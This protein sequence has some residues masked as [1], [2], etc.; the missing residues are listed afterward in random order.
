M[1]LPPPHAPPLPKAIEQIRRKY[2]KGKNFWGPDPLTCRENVAI[3]D[4]LD[5]I[6]DLQRRIREL[7]TM[8]S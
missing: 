1:N 7:E 4:L 6:E 5:V 3:N 8:L 2:N